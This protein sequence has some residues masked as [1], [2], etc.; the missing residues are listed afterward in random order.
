MQ[1]RMGESPVS[2]LPPSEPFVSVPAN[3][4]NNTHCSAADYERLYAQ[5]I[6]DPDTF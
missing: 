2:E 5:S 4:A 3:A 1:T 6:S